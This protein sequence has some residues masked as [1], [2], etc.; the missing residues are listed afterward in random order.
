VREERRK[1]EREGRRE[2]GE[3]ILELVEVQWLPD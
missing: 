1:E 3:A 2:G